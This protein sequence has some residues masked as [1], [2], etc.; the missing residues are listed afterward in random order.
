MSQEEL[1][2]NV[3]PL[4]SALQEWEGTVRRQ[5]CPVCQVAPRRMAPS[6]GIELP[7]MQSRL[8]R[9]QVVEGSAGIG[10]RGKLA[11]K[12]LSFLI[13]VKDHTQMET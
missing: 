9:G 2:K 7:S 8:K 5:V 13:T 4:R 10:G 1:W 11:R 12:F 6:G 3:S